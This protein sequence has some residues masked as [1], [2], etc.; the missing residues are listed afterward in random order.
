MSKNSQNSQKSRLYEFRILYNAESQHS[1]LDSYHYYMAENASD[2]F[3][4]HRKAMRKL[5]ACAQN[6]AVE[7]Y[8]PYSERWEDE[9][10]LV[11]LKDSK[12]CEK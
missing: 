7:R 10:H 8:N 1:F 2:A 6:L 3:K 11:N 5:H 9:T 4:F 12:S